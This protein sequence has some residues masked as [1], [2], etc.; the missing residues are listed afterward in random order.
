MIPTTFSR[1]DNSLLG[2]WWWTVDRLAISLLL[3]LIVI[4]VFLSFAASPSV[5]ERL[6][7]GTF[8]FVKRHIIMIIPAV[9]VMIGV[10]LFSPISIRRLSL[11]M[12]ILGIILL[13]MTFIFGVEVKGARR[14]LMIFGNSIQASEFV[15]PAI[16]VIT[17][18]LIAEK[19]H[20]EK[21]PGITLS[22]VA[23]GIIVGL[24]LLQPDLGMTIVIIATW[25]GQL[26]IAGLPIFWMA[27]LAGIAI[28]GLVGAYWLLPHVTKR[29]DQ[30]LDPSAG[31][32]VHDLYQ[33]TKSLAAF[34]NGGFFG[35][36][37]GEGVIKKNVPD[38][39]A[40]FVFAVA[41]EEFGLWMCII[42]VALFMVIIIRFMMRATKG[43]SLFI[44]LST[45]GLAVQFGLQAFINMASTLHLIPTKG[46]TM[47]FIS[48]GG[49]SMVALAICAGMLL[50]LTRKRHG[51]Q[52]WEE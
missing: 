19:M 1:R 44:L 10:S 42:I 17:A 35:K 8:F 39:H 48:Y 2:R 14:W 46:M 49:S 34:A 33:I 43:S 7:L 31:N 47:P 45:T 50:A 29:I 51:F 20:D 23:V 41:G 36:G 24:L 18:W 27:G 6:N 12:Y 16:T 25:V 22:M 15:K 26:F 4:G 9:A 38:A 28:A 52:D 11:L 5:A 40:D 13:I 30:F 32:P 37:P 21:F 3:I